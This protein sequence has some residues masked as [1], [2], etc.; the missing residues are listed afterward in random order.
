MAKGYEDEYQALVSN[1]T[2][3]LVDFLIGNKPIGCKW[4]FKSKHNSDGSFQRHKARLLK[5]LAELK[6]QIEELFIRPSVSPWGALVLLVNK[7]DGS[8][9]LCVDYRQLN[10]VTIKNKY[11][12]PRIDDLMDQLV[13]ACV[14]SKI[15][16]RSGYHQ[17]RVKFEDIPKTAFRTHYGHYEYLVMPFG[18]TNAPGV[19]IDYM[20]RIF[21]QYL[22]RFVVVFTDDILVYS[23]TREEHTENLRIVMQTLKDKQLYAKFSR[24]EFWLNSVEQ[25]RGKE[26]PLVKV[27]WGGNVEENATWEEVR[28]RKHIRFYLLQVISGTKF[29]KRWESCNIP[30]FL[31]I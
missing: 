30:K 22:D 1:Q 25:L 11:P 5:E 2:W 17:I 24:C 19:F 16:L 3:S 7:K 8:I 21:Q 9:R 23:K 10:K 26:I 13:G 15:D 31:L 29:L 27:V 14:F 6:K 20:N 18:V 12:L 28:C 4:I